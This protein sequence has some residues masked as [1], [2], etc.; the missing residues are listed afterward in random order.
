MKGGGR[1]CFHCGEQGHWAMQ[2]PKKMAQQQSAS[3]ALARQNAPQ[4]GAGN[5]GQTRYNHGRLN[6]LEAEGI[7]EAPGMILGTFSVE[8]HSTKLLFDSGATHSFV[9]ASWVEAHNLPITTMTT[10]IQIYSACHVT[11]QGIR[12]TYGCPCPKDLRQ[13]CRCT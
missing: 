1:G 11:S 7:Q 2:C 3:N 8:S 5:R 12:P 13:S 9:T 10:P 4:Q 6:H